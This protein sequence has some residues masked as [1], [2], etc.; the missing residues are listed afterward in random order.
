MSFIQE[1]ANSAL[2]DDYLQKLME[3]TV[4]IY[5]LNFL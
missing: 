4:H 3:K 1:L 5:G 2:K